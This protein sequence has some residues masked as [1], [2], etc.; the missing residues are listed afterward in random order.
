MGCSGKE[1]LALWDALRPKVEQLIREKTRSTVRKKKMN[2][3]AIDTT[4]QTVTVYEASNPTS[5]ITIP[6][7]AW[8]GIESLTPGQSV[9]VE[10][11][12]DDLSTAVA[13]TP[14]RGY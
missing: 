2:L 4:A 6:Y 10:W 8:T 5:T 9:I 14:G 13:V 1:A 7:R 3:S 12:F 11:I